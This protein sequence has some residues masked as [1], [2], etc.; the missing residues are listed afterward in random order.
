MI[1]RDYREDDAGKICRLFYETVRSVNLK[2]YS[3]EQVLGAGPTRPRCLAR[4]HVRPAHAGR[5]G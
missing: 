3:P 4:T 2:D 1:V 5:G